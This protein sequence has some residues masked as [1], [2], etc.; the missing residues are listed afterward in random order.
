MRPCLTSP[1]SRVHVPASI[2][3]ASAVPAAAPPR[4]GA[5]ACAAPRA[6]QISPR[7]AAFPGCSRSRTPHSR[8][9]RGALQFLLQHLSAMRSAS[10]TSCRS[11]QLRADSHAPETA[12]RR[13][14]RSGATSACA[15][16]AARNRCR[17]RPS[18]PIRPCALAC[19]KARAYFLLSE[20]PS[21]LV[22]GRCGERGVAEARRG[23][24]GG[25][26]PGRHCWCSA[27][28]RA[29]L[30]TTCISASRRRSRSRR[31]SIRCSCSR[32][33]RVLTGE[34]TALYEFP[35]A[36]RSAE[37]SAPLRTLAAEPARTRAFTSYSRT[38]CTRRFAAN[39]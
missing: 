35:I 4:E 26:S 13:L 31:T 19:R 17:R 16:G 18:K 36:P 30:H 39:L 7:S 37:E 27:R 10:A 22:L 38:R 34:K 1:I 21:R 15:A 29:G 28:A 2:S 5:A 33:A 32:A 11:P 12:G 24:F 14:R 3:S 23:R 20:H 6:A 25:E 8:E 9:W